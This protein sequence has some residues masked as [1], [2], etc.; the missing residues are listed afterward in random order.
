VFH[1]YQ[2]GKIAARVSYLV[3]T[4]KSLILVFVDPSPNLHKERPVCIFFN[5]RSRRSLGKTFHAVM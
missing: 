2:E 5:R 3:F 4:L 1:H